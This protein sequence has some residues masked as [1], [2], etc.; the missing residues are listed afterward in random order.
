V[1]EQERAQ[2]QIRPPD[3]TASERLGNVTMSLNNEVSLW[4]KD[5]A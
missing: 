5:E 2:A 1:D 3:D 4:Q